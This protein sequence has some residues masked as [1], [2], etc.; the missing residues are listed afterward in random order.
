MAANRKRHNHP[1]LESAEGLG[2]KLRGLKTNLSK[3]TSLN[4]YEIHLEFICWQETSWSKPG[5]VGCVQSRVFVTDS[6]AGLLF[7]NSLGNSHGQEP[8]QVL[9]WGHR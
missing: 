5:L 9:L 4:S 2:A 3:V 6:D 7:S 1:M 8:N